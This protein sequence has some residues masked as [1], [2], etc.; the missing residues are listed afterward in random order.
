[1]KLTLLYLN[2]LHASSDGFSSSLVLLLPFI[3]SDLKLSLTQVGFLGSSFSLLTILLALP[4]GSLS[5]KFGGMR[6]LTA[7]V[8]A[9]GLGYILQAYSWSF[10]T[11]LPIFL[12]SGAGYA[13][14]NPIGYGLIARFSEKGTRGKVIGTFSAFG[15]IGKLILTP[16]LTFIVAYLGWRN[17]SLL[18]GALALLFFAFLVFSHFKNRSIHEKQE[19]PLDLEYKTLL[20]NKRFVFAVSSG[21]LDYM[22]SYPLF[23]FLPFVLLQKGIPGIFLGSFLGLYFIGNL[24]GKN[25]LGRMTDRRGHVKTFVIAEICTAAAIFLMVLSHNS[26]LIAALALALGILGKGTTPITQTMVTESTE[27]HKNF[28]KSI[29]LYSLIG[30][31]AAMAGTIILGA[32]ADHLG[33]NRAFTFTAVLALLAI[34]PALAF[35]R[36][37]S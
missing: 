15:D 35:A 14:F 6:V 25:F 29:S 20:E 33:V 8:L 34:L 28:E 23:I 3:A 37:K 21:V 5:I 7:A 22:S 17:T 12:L 24:L 26:H 10:A 11:L 32:A 4:A 30:N 31:I 13:L 2:L 18:Y 9:Y 19:K 1:M 16:G 27:H 36:V